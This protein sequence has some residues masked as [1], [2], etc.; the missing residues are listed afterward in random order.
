MYK[1]IGM[2]QVYFC[3]YFCLVKFVKEILESTI[4]GNN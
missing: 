4:K 1:I 2:F 3:E